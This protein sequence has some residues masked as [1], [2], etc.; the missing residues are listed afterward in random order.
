MSDSDPFNDD[1][2]RAEFARHA[3]SLAERARTRLGA[4]VEPIKDKAKELA[5]THKQSSAEKIG[6][7]AATVRHAADDLERDL[8]RTAGYI[9]QAADTMERASAALK[10]RSVDELI[11]SLEQF[12][13]NQPAAFFGAAVLAG[14]ALSRFIKSSP[15]Q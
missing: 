1:A 12:A 6:G 13:R 5:E 14:F 7:V 8:P 9:H 2:R 10:E 3:A 11:G 4:A 15:H